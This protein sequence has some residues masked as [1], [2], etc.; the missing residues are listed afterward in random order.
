MAMND[1]KF[2]ELLREAGLGDYTE[3]ILQYK[4]PC[5]RLHARPIDDSA[6]L[7]LGASRI[8]GLPDL[9]P[10]MQ[11]PTR[12]GRP[13]EFIAQINLSEASPYDVTGL[14]P[15][16]GTLLFFYDGREYED[17][18][19]QNF[20]KGGE[21]I[22]Y[23]TSDIAA[24]ERANYPEALQELQRYRVCSITFETDWMLPHWSEAA[25]RLE[26]QVLGHLGLGTY[27]PT[28][29]MVDSY[30]EMMWELER[31]IKDQ[32]IHHLLGYPSPVI[33]DDPLYTLPG[34]WDNVKIDHDLLKDWI[35]LLQISS[36][37]G[38]GM[39]WGD[40]SSIYYCIRRD[41]LIA[42]Q[43]VNAICVRNNT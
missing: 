36:D 25:I 3:A 16:E 9:P 10:D 43:F 6:S 22:R 18:H 40:I 38:P 21:T 28:N 27:G 14:L 30:R 11:W 32:D 41:D 24:L 2:A 1:A 23:F 7:P 20:Q 19:Y 39:L 5:V 12:N 17:V 35:Y 37:D 13:C 4:K 8:G 31:T 34:A 15:K 26:Q 33:Q 42:W 29:P